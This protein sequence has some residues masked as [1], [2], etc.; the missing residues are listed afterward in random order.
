[1]YKKDL[2]RNVA[3][4]LNMKV[5]EVEAVL[6]NAFETIVIAVAEGEN[7]QIAGLGKFERVVS[8]GRE[9]VIA[10][11]DRA[12]QHYKTEDKFSPKFRPAKGFKDTVA[13]R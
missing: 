11:G 13:S 7:V 9:G 5:K 4:S 12:G 1:M 10:F 6:D 8:K 3:E 2:A